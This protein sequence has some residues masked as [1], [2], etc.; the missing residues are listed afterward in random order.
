MAEWN[1][2]KMTLTASGSCASTSSAII[3]AWLKV[4]RTL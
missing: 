1:L 4:V 2:L 3:D